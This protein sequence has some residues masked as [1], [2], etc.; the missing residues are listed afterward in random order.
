MTPEDVKRAD[1]LLHERRTV[2]GSRWNAVAKED[3]DERWRGYTPIPQLV[4]ADEILQAAIDEFRL[5]KL[6]EID[7]QLRELGV[8]T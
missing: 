8:E 3:E 6:A 2:E 5:R 1:R 4:R 7:D